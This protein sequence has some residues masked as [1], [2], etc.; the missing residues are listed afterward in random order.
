MLSRF[1]SFALALLAAACGE[2]AGPTDQVAAPLCGNGIV[3]SGEACDLTSPG[4]VDCQVAAGWTCD[5]TS[6]TSTCGDGIVGSGPDCADPQR[7]TDCDMTG[8]W[9]EREADYSLDAVVQSPQAQSDWHLIHFEQTG[10]DFEVTEEID[11]GLHVSGAAAVDFSTAT[12][13]GLIYINRMDG[14]EE[15]TDAGGTHP[16]RRGTSKASEGGCAVTIERHYIQRGLDDSWLP[17]DFNAG[18]AL[19]D[20]KP[21]PTA[22]S[23]PADAGPDPVNSTEWP[24]GATDTEADGIPGAAFQVTG[25]VTGT[26]NAVQRQWREYAS[27]PGAPVPAHAIE[28]DVQGDYDLH[29]NVIRVTDCGTGCSLLASGSHTAS[30]AR[31]RPH[32]VL[33]FIGK[34][35]GSASV[36]AVVKKKLRE[37]IDADMETCK[38]VRKLLPHDSAIPKG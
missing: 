5:A 28:I 19:K 21:L 3:E 20:L 10:N 34:T 2:D 13:R 24:A 32:V 18:V 11:C 14:S 30:E 38:N 1:A 15:P 17:S 27:D 29:E 4:C 26:R 33:H 22:G 7:D 35:L 37:D 23:G 25:T 9:M 31:F 12:L 16:A 8:Y 6:C 36:S